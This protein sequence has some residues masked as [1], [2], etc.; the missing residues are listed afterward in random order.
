ME[1]LSEHDDLPPVWAAWGK[2]AGRDAHHPLICHAVDTALVA[3]K[4]FPV[5]LGPH[6][7]AE[8]RKAFAPLGDE[9]AWIAVLCGLHDLGKYSATFQSLDFDL[10]DELLGEWAR[11]DIEYVRKPLGLTG[12]FDT[13]HGLLTALHMKDLLTSWGA[14]IE[15]AVSIAAVLGGHHGYFQSNDAVREARRR[16]NDHGSTR[17][18]AWRTAMALDL[19]RLL[20]LPHPASLPWQDVHLSTSACVCFAALTTVSDWIASDITNF[21]SPEAGFDLASY[22]RSSA[23]S[24]QIAVHKVGVAPW[25]PPAR[26]SFAALFPQDSPRPVQEVVERLTADVREPVLLVVEAPTGEGKTKAALQ[27]MTAI[28]R[29]LGQA[30]GYV[31]MPTQATSNQALGEIEAMLATIGDATPVQLVHSNAKDFLTQRSTTPSDVGRDEPGVQDLIAL[32]WFTRKK[33]LLAPLGVG[34]IDQALK[35]S[36]RSGHVFVRLAALSNKVVVIDEIHAY[37]TYMSRLLDRLLT[38]LGSLGTSVVLLSATLP[39]ERRAGLVAAWQAGRLGCSIVRAPLLPESDHYPR[40]TV[41]RTSTPEVHPAGVS[42]VNEQRRIHLTSVSDDDVVD[43][44]LEHAQAGRG[45]AVVHNLVR[46][47]IATYDALAE[48]IAE[49]PLDQR[50]ELIAINGPMAA[51]ERFDTEA[52]L[53]SYF[54]EKGSRPRAIVVGTQ[55]LEQSLDLD[56]DVMLTDLAPVDSMIQ[57]MGRVHRHNR[58]KSRGPQVLGITGVEDTPEGPRFPRYTTN[59]YQRIVLMRTWAV[60][61][62][63]A[64]IESPTDV[65]KLVDQVYRGEVECPAG[66]E[67]TWWPA[68]DQLA[69][70]IDNDRKSAENKYL[71]IPHEIEHLYMVTERSANPGDTRKGRG[72]R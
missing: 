29:Q 28:A 45:V 19:V 7:R 26:T 47:A 56:F 61:S 67:K 3:E 27:A 53:R 68:V 10:A 54:G 66:W 63:K 40:V 50:P 21:A 42:E 37:D 22:V 14:S 58:D 2:S 31:A 44:L 57:R 1:R 4:L 36:I 32:T 59:V 49:L 38:W 9:V 51:R 71:P 48:R 23:V 60:L 11:R 13:P 65:P 55:V 41:A 25:S 24:A 8:L 5:M 39:S 20:G 43:W 18:S 64:H 70:A 35:G 72:R 15:T 6:V 16:T 17:W 34:T 33:N 62:G 69:S 12:Q 30:G 46:R 52:E